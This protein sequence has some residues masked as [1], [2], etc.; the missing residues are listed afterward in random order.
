MKKIIVITFL[1]FTNLSTVSYERDKEHL[2]S[3]HQHKVLIKGEDFEIEKE[4]LDRFIYGLNAFQVA[5]INVNG[6]VC[7]FC[8][9]GIQKTFLKDPN[10]EKIDVDL[11][12][13]KVTIAYLNKDPINFNNIKEKIL[14][15]GQTATSMKLIKL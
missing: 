14:S 8:A 7:D 2:H 13:G 10:V 5:I 9:R 15:N 11:A 1:L 4:K 3:Q 6:M 12:K